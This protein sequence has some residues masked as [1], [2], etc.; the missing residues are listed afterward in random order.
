M[1]IGEI[2]FGLFLIFIGCFATIAG[3]AEIKEKPWLQ[4]HPL[5]WGMSG[6][7]WVGVMGFVC[8]ALWFMTLS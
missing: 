1:S 3:I 6:I 8:A 7:L 2:L 4:G 5:N